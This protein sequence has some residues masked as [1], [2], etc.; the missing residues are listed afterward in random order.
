MDQQELDRFMN[1]EAGGK[2]LVWNNYFQVVEDH[3]LPGERLTKEYKGQWRNQ[4]GPKTKRIWEGFGIIK[5]PDGS[6][7]QGQTSNEIF[8][9]KGRMTHANGDIYH[10][11]WLDGKANGFGV[12]V[13]SIGSSYKGEWLDD[14]QHG[15]GTESW[16]F[17]KIKYTGE[18]K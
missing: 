6:L 3:N 14:Q 11:D 9:G 10:G 17:G 7:Y 8:N 18:F 13:D 1:S 15:F 2:N 16:N 12:F 4:V 5:F